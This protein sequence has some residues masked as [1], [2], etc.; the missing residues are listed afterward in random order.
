MAKKVDI[1]IHTNEYREVNRQRCLRKRNMRSLAEMA[2]N[3]ANASDETA[4]LRAA[5]D[6]VR[7][8]ARTKKAT[9]NE[10]NIAIIK[11]ELLKNVEKGDM[12]TLDSASQILWNHSLASDGAR[13]SLALL[14]ALDDL[15]NKGTLERRTMA[16]DVSSGTSH[17]NVYVVL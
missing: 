4:V 13:G 7:Q 12:F 8:G 16:H 1:T 17:V 2:N 3:I 15:V 10:H 9:A 6:I 5:W 14:A 11:N